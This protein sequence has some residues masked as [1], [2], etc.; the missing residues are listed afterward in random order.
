MK[1]ILVPPTIFI[2]STVKEFADI[3]SALAHNLRALGFFVYLSESN[4]FEIS[5]DR[6]AMDECFTNI[7]KSDVFILIVGKTKGTPF[8]DDISVTRQEFRVA[9]EASLNQSRPRLLLYLRNEAEATLDSNT[10]DGA[11][12]A[13]FI[14]EIQ[15]PQNPQ[16]P[17]FLHRFNDSDDLM[18]SLET[19]LNLGRNLAEQMFRHVLL[20]ELLENLSSILERKDKLVITHN[21]YFSNTRD[22]IQLTTSDIGNADKYINITREHAKSIIYLLTGKAGTTLKTN[23]IEDAIEQGLLLSFN[24]ATGQLT[25]SPLHNAMKLA[26]KDIQAIQVTDSH[27]NDNKW[28]INILAAI[29]MGIKRNALKIQVRAIDLVYLLH[30]YDCIENVFQG[31]LAIC[32]VLLGVCDILPQYQRRPS[33]PLGENM[34]NQINNETITASEVSQLITN[35]LLSIGNQISK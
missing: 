28:D 1:Q 35:G 31:H 12:L 23:V 30:Y 4:E 10:V 25:E 32:Q 7:R 5:G 19:N 20:N 17:N 34:E 21:S 16:T 15:E 29:S 2:S 11:H 13:S 14:N 18:K 24:S 3:R 22:Q 8:I 6:S 26:L 27:P 33:T 9:R